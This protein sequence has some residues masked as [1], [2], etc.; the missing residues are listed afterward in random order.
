M[1]I[2]I[3]VLCRYDSNRLPG[4]I[5]K[6]I[7]G[8]PILSHII[9]R[10]NKVNGNHPICVATSTSQ[11]DRPLINYCKKQR[12]NYFRGNKNNVASRFLNCALK[13]N[14]DYAIRINGDN[15]F[16]DPSIINE[17]IKLTMQNKWLFLTNVLNR[18]FPEG[19]SVEIIKISFMK[20]KI[21]LFNQ[22]EKEHVMPYFYKNLKKDEIYEYKNN[23]YKINP[24]I[25]LAVDTQKDFE[26]LSNII[27]SM[28]K[29]PHLYLT[30]EILK[31]I[32]TLKVI[33]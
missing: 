3:I 7:K 22:Y 18:T 17:M 1:K 11:N 33:S 15:L 2:G 9:D 25:K 4:K 5:L 8:K 6:N 19:I 16:T 26:F 10:L 28:D 29:P 21:N 13:M 14:L 20:I 31:I 12:I 30:S 27:N 24:Q 32:K 23:E